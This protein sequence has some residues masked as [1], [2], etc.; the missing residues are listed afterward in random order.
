MNRLAC[1]ALARM[2]LS[3]ISALFRKILHCRM[4]IRV[5]AGIRI[6]FHAWLTV[7][8]LRLRCLIIPLRL[9]FFYA[10]R[11]CRDMHINTYSRQGMPDVQ[12]EHRLPPFPWAL[13]VPSSEWHKSGTHHAS[14]SGVKEYYSSFIL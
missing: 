3:L 6:D 9:R 14:R 10:A 11:Q 7:A 1:T 8:E 13:S 5:T 2:T 4:T 12:I